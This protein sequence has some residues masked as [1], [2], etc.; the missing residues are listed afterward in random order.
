VNAATI[1]AGAYQLAIQGTS[2]A[3]T[4]VL[5]VPIN[6]GDYLV[7]W[8]QTLTVAPGA[9][10]IANLTIASSNLYRGTVTVGC[11]ASALT[12][13]TCTLIP[14]GP[15]TVGQGAV[16]A[17]TATIT[18]PGIAVSGAYKININTQDTTGTPSH[19]LTSMVDVG[20]Y[21]LAVSQPFGSVDAGAQPQAALTITPIASFPG[22]VNAFCDAS[23][24]SGTQCS[25]SPANPIVISTTAITLRATVNVPNGA[26]PGTYNININRQ[27]GALSHSLTIPP[28]H[29]ANSS[30]VPRST[31]CSR[32]DD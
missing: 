6:V 24:L 8:T 11:D 25:L 14:T 26:A 28:D 31:C 27:D 23:A 1:V 22:S 29:S 12:G 16:V 21:Q 17:V 15:I 5:A 32:S 2:G 7:S 19:A 20:D 4:H 18:V 3:T 13:A 9:Q 10:A 30:A